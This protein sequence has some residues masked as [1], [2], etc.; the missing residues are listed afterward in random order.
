MKID[1]TSELAQLLK[2]AGDT[3]TA[4]RMYSH[5]SGGRARNGE[6]YR[7]PH[8]NPVDLMFLSDAISQLPNV[9]GAIERGNPAQI[10]AACLYVQK[11]FES[12]ATD[13]PTFDPQAKPTFDYWAGSVD[14]GVA[15]MALKGIRA[16]TVTAN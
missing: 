15:V 11:L 9:A 12:Y 6:T 13:N 10:V 14:L 1:Y 4:I 8:M 5:Y 3:A 2:F 16:K 7:D